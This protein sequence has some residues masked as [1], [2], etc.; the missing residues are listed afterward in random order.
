MKKKAKK[1]KKA[2]PRKAARTKTSTPT[3]KTGVTP[4]NDSVLVRPFSPDELE[5]KVTSFG[6]IIPETAKKKPDQGVVLAVGP[7]RRNDEGARIPLDVKV[8]DRV[9]FKKPWDDPMSINGVECYIVSESEITL[10]QK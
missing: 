6:I 1:V 2:L 3:N 8:G 9:Y 7:G 4:L 5:N 10:I